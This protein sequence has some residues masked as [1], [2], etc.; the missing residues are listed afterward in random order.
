LWVRVRTCFFFSCCCFFLLR[1]NGY[2]CA[3]LFLRDCLAS[4]PPENVSVSV[5]VLSVV[6]GHIPEK[7]LCNAKAY[8]EPS[9]QWHRENDTEIIMKGNALIL[10]YPIPRTSGGNYVCEAF[11]R[12]GNITHKTFINVLRTT[13]INTF[14]F[15][16]IFNVCTF[17]I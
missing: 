7:I 14:F 11:N 10:N 9:Y 17:S 2:S 13:I 1:M 15:L 8:P 6:E 5:P 3:N 4:D 16:S 12:H